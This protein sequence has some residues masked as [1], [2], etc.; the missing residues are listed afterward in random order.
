MILIGCSG[1]TKIH[2]PAYDEQILYNVGHQGLENVP[3][4]AIGPK[5]V[6]IFFDGTGNDLNTTTNVARLYQLVINQ[7]RSD[8]SAFYTSGVGAD[9]TGAIGLA[10][11]LGF[12][13]DVQAAY[14]FL[15]DNY[16]GKK[17]KIHLYG[18]SRGAF[19]AR[20]LAGLVHTV[21][22]VDL[23]EIKKRSVRERFLHNLFSAYKF[24]KSKPRAPNCTIR[25]GAI[26][27]EIDLRRCA[28]QEVL[29]KYDIKPAYE[30][31]DVRFAVVGL[32]DTIE[33][34]G[35][36]DW[37][38]DPDETNHRYSDQICNMDRVFH[39]VA[40][41]DNRAGTYTPILMTR[42]RL[43]RDCESQAKSQ[44]ERVEEVWFAG[45]HAQV[46][47]TENVGYLSGVSLNWMLKKTRD[48][49]VGNTPLFPIG[50]K[51]YEQPYE[52]VKDVQKS[53]LLFRLTMK[54]QMRGVRCY[55][56]EGKRDD[57]RDGSAV[58]IIKIHKSAMAR[59]WAITIPAKM[60]QNTSGKPPTGFENRED[61]VHTDELQDRH[62][63]P[64]VCDIPDNFDSVVVD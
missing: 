3:K 7:D 18:Y 19:S 14:G 34:L 32:W 1:A 29:K 61:V 9:G 39:A 10:T 59:K 51:V 56:S 54:R 41:H 4:N 6:A 50:S 38:D 62:R 30:H 35:L 20:A 15:S 27:E 53:S 46:G 64:P 2:N 43:V 33:T 5:N 36:P 37:T 28:T 60:R 11:G 63:S 42:N 57:L 55:T 21:G 31:A 12:R 26:Q 48:I 58:Q 40:L 22:L 24:P 23:S 49:G 44:F 8:I 52:Y 45:D 17:D 47:G 25:T 13:R 16:A